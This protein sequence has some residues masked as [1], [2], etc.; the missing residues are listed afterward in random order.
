MTTKF[1]DREIDDDEHVDANI[2]HEHHDNHKQ[3]QQSQQNQKNKIKLS[4][5]NNIVTPDTMITS[6]ENISPLYH[7]NRHSI[8]SQTVK[9]TPV[10]HS[11]KISEKDPKI[12]Y[13]KKE[14]YIKSKNK[15]H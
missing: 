1:M 14:R 4:T 12:I 8:E 13:H 9:S 3:H 7:D 11:P 10:L 2:H 6:N 15:H 5:K